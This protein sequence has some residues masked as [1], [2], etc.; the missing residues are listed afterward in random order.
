MRSFPLGT[1]PS[2]K[3]RKGMTAIL[4]AAG[5][6]KRMGPGAGH[7]CL[8]RVGGRSLLRRTL[9]GLRAVGVGEVALVTGFQSE[10]VAAEARSHAGGMKLTVLENPRYKEGASLSLWT[11]REFLDRDVLVM[12]ADVLCPQAAFERLVGSKHRNC[13][14]AD[15]SVRETGEEQILFGREGRVLHIAKK[16]PEEIRRRMEL[17]G[18]SL[19][20]L[21]LEAAAAALLRKFL[22]QKVQAGVVTIEHEQVYPDLFGQATV[23]FELVDGLAWIEIDTPEDLARAER[24]VYRSWS[25]LK[26]VN[27]VISGWF[28]PLVLRLPLTPNR[29]T[30]V[31]LMLGSGSLWFMSRGSRSGEL[32]G[33]LLF[34][35]FYLADNWDGEV[36]RAKGLSTRWGGWFDVM[37]DAVIQIDLPLALAIGLHRAGGPDWVMWLGVAAFLGVGLDFWI[38]LW[39]KARGFGPA[40]PGDSG[41]S[42]SAPAG[43]P[44]IQWL[45]TNATQEN[46]SWVVVLALLLRC[47][48]ALLACM[49]V[50]C[51]W[52]WIRFLSKER[53]RLT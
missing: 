3:D 18:E 12:D 25:G 39:A 40:I 22:D 4:L 7:K 9:E 24:E 14:L 21:R 19:G 53:L 49:A 41:Q 5:V 10:A 30:L 37:V 11:A 43:S 51:Q 15:G 50:G 28:L 31:S 1:P 34:Q 17:Y 33:A 48:L 6:G 35:L 45:R 44:V 52:F 2:S 46:F 36:A 8:A 32:W 47:E 42:G 27:R 13:L 16:A 20:F 38:T 23:G 26:C 29:W